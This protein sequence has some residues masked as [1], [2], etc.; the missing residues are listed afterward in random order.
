MNERIR[1]K[2][3]E[4]EK[5][6][7]ELGEIT[8]ENFEDYLED[9]KTRAACE[10]YAEKIIGAVIDLAFMIIREKGLN[11]PDSELHMFD[12]LKE[13]D[14][15]SEK[16]SRKLQDAKGMRNIIAHEYGKVDD[17]IVFTSI[18]EELIEDVEEYLRCISE[19]N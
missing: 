11:Q 12:I 15:I 16:L 5:Y 2:I 8:P 10:R 3:E 13:N 14:V 7:D 9:Y 17:E 6:L 18:K 1:S 4:L 19:K